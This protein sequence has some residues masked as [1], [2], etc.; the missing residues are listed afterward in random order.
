MGG[1]QPPQV[2]GPRSQSQGRPG[3]LGHRPSEPRFPHEGKR[4]S[5]CFGG[6][7]QV[8]VSR[9]QPGGGTCAELW[10]CRG[11]VSPLCA[12]VSLSAEWEYVNHHPLNCS[13][14]FLQQLSPLPRC[15]LLLPSSRWDGNL[16]FI[17]D[18]AQPPALLPPPWPPSG[19]VADAGLAPSSPCACPAGPLQSPCRSQSECDPAEDEV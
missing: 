9:Q 10:F 12:S 16:G 6:T 7:Q 11:Q 4:L 17:Q 18:E 5:L 15:W 19:Q 14:Q 3:E 1:A 13:T 2:V 8:R